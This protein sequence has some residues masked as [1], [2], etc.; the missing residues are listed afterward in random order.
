MSDLIKY[1]FIKALDELEELSLIFDNLQAETAILKQEYAANP[2]DEELLE[3]IK[4]HE[5]KYKEVYEKFVAL[6]E[7]SKQLK[8]AS[9]AESEEDN[10]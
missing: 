1:E 3:R 2:N 6:N 9:D 5:T 4:I 7:K 8:E 10:N